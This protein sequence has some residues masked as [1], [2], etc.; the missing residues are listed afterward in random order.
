MSSEWV[1]RADPTWEATLLFT[2]QQVICVGS[3][4]PVE[5]DRKPGKERVALATWVQFPVV[6]QMLHSRRVSGRG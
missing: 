6:G 4:G 1:R 2:C 3:V 5:E